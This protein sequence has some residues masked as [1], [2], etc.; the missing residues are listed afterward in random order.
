MNIC[1]ERVYSVFVIV[2]KSTGKFYKCR[3]GKCAWEKTGHAK[4]AFKVCT[5]THFD[6][7]EI[8]ELREYVAEKSRNG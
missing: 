4:N 5:G 7:Q 1:S 6:D 3:S 8:F 2:E